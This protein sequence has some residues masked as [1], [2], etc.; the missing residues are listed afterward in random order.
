MS[1]SDDHVSLIREW[2]ALVSGADRA[3]PR[4]A[5]GGKGVTSSPT[6]EGELAEETRGC[7]CYLDLVGC[8]AVRPGRSETY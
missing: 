8:D 6:G 2:P 4:M 7:L 5:G 3:N 1:L